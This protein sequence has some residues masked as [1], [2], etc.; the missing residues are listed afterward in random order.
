MGGMDLAVRNVTGKEPD[1]YLADYR[2]RSNFR[3][4]EVKEAIGV[5]SRT[6][7]FNPTYIKEKMKGGSSEANAFAELVQNTYGWNVMK[8]DAI[9][10]EIW[11]EIYETYVKDQYDLGT[12]QYFEDKNPAAIE[13]ITAVM[14]ESARKGMWKATD[15]Q[16]KD[17]AQ[18]HTEIVNKYKPS[19]SGF[20]CDNAKLRQYIEQQVD[21]ASAQEY[22][23]NINDIRTASGKQGTVMKKE[24][25]Q[26]ES[27][28]RRAVVSNTL[29]VVGALLLLVG[30]VLFIRKRRKQSA[31]SND[32]PNT[33]EF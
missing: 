10:N 20:V 23:K 1:A 16:L 17:V 15:Q 6:T 2:N 24:T 33:E 11:D 18:L 30:S 31:G 32:K 4:Q 12:K 28:S 13:E 7:L 25:I 5:E 26:D 27:A 14:M 22:R 9:D 21:E 8:P 29:I 3:M 19:C